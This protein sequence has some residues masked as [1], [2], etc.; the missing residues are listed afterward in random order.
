M[1]FGKRRRQADRHEVKLRASIEVLG[2]ASI[3]CVVVNLSETGALL[4]RRDRAFVPKQFALTLV[5]LGATILCETVRTTTTRIGVRF[6]LGNDTA[7][8]AAK[9]MIRKALGDR[10]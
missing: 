10:S 6:V 9:R 4:E 7:S 2:R 3:G 5:A 1:V 8:L